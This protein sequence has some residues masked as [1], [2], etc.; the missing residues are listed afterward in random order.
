MGLIRLVLLY[1]CDHVGCS[2]W[3]T[4]ITHARTKHAHAQ[5]LWWFSLVLL[6]TFLWNK[7]GSSSF[8]L[9]VNQILVG[10]RL[11]KDDTNSTVIGVNPGCYA[12][13]DDLEL[14][15]WVSYIS[16]MYSPPHTVL[17]SLTNTIILKEFKQFTSVVFNMAV[18][19]SP[20]SLTVATNYWF[21][22]MTF[23]GYTSRVF[24]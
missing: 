2:L 4:D 3:K 23:S 18:C 11:N 17:T 21:Y 12:H 22:L 5:L 8:N 16:T 14:A 7:T 13:A 1:T 15:Q 10:N 19:L 9:V 24:K 6:L 20:T